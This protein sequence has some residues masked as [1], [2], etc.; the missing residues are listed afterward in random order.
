MGRAE[1]AHLRMVLRFP[2]AR[3]LMGA[4]I[5][6]SV[7]SLL[8]LLSSASSHGVMQ[9]PLP[10]QLGNVQDDL[11]RSSCVSGGCN[12]FTNWT[13]TTGPTMPQ[14]S[15]LRSFA[16]VPPRFIDWT[17]N[18]PWRAPGRARVYS[19]CGSEG[20]NPDGC[21]QVDGSTMGRCVTDDGGFGFGPDGRSLGGLGVTT[22]WQQGSQVEAGWSVRSNHG[23]GYSYRLCKK[24]T[25]G[26]YSKITEECFTRLP[27]SFVGDTSWVQYGN[28][29]G[30][31]EIDAL[32]TTTGTFPPGSQWTRNPIPSFGHGPQVMG[33]GT[34]FPLPTLHGQPVQTPSPLAGFCP[35]RAR[36]VGSGPPWD[37]V[38]QGRGTG[39]AGG[40]WVPR[41][42]A[43]SCYCCCSCCGHNHW[44]PGFDDWV[45]VDRLQVPEDLPTGDY[46][47]GA[48]GAT[49]VSHVP[50]CGCAWAVRSRLAPPD[51]TAGCLLQD[52]GG[53]A[54]SRRR[55][56]SNAHRSTSPRPPR[57]R[58]PH[59]SRRCAA[60][61]PTPAAS[62]KPSPPASER[63]QARA[64][65]GPR[66]ARACFPR[67]TARTVRLCAP[68]RAR[69][70][71]GV[72]R[73]ARGSEQ[74]P[75]PLSGVSLLA[76]LAV[77]CPTP[78]LC[79]TRSQ[80]L[81]V[82][83]ERIPSVAAVGRGCRRC[84]PQT[85]ALAGVATPAALD[86][87][88]RTAWRGVLASGTRTG[89][90]AAGKAR[91][92]APNATDGGSEAWMPERSSA[93]N[94]HSS[95]VFQLCKKK[96]CHQLIPGSRRKTKFLSGRHRANNTVKKR[97]RT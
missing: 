58:H 54:S 46:V 7:L 55:C 69:F 38:R 15:P 84:R 94:R 49:L 27:L 81:N 77:L 20:G 96:A 74:A 24:P 33:N 91:A 47:L 52:S 67:S 43:K 14:S 59:S 57:H 13:F 28:G 16:D 22:S 23:G 50:A 75:L 51:Q 87:L 71:R 97:D 68:S 90:A 76:C 35:C 92:P 45:L 21:I 6:L 10:W 9:I 83:A 25:D 5:V 36:D 86:A 66:S 32:R 40:L 17:A 3:H 42:G 78:R 61:R 37:A 95:Y 48:F 89:A 63:E 1:H 93:T 85:A 2:Q 41:D 53:T 31:F 12:W 19:P 30:R 60:T 73:S 64:R 72:V 8:S 62:P 80:A 34:Q 88:A 26:N 79:A 65:C 4:P 70:L 11:G 44:N 82:S 39:A 56:G 18:H 29:S